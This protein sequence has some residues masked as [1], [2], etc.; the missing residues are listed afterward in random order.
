MCEITMSPEEEESQPK[1][2]LGV[3][4]IQFVLLFLTLIMNYGQRTS[5]SVAIIAMTE[6]TPPGPDIHT[7]PQWKDTD[8]ILSSF[9]W[10]YIVTQ[11]G[12]GQLGERFGPKW[13]LV[14][15]MVLGSIV[16]CLTT[17]MA[18]A[19]GSAGVITCQIIQGLNQGFLCPCVHILISQWAPLN[20]RTRFSII[21]YSGQSLGIVIS[22]LSTGAISGSKLGWPYVFYF[23]GAGGI[24]W[25]IIFGMFAANSPAD[26]KSISAEERRY[27]ESTNSVIQTKTK[28]PTPWLSIA[29]SLPFW[30]A[31]AAS[32]AENWGSYTL[33]T[34][35]P[36]FM[37]SVM[38]YDINSNSQLSALPYM[39]TFFVNFVSS[40]ISDKLISSKT[41]SIGTTRKIFNSLG[42]LVP[43]CAL[44]ALGFIDSTQKGVAVGLLVVSVAMSAC[45]DAGGFVN[46]IDLAPNHVGTLLGIT[47]GTGQIFSILAPLTVGFLGSD[48]TDLMLWR[49]VFWIA[50]GIYVFCGL[51]FNIFASGEVQKWNDVKSTDKCESESEEKS[52]ENLKFLGE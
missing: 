52:N 43:G 39:V 27:I 50:A 23:Y 44:F 18:Q 42:T 5:I 20:E 26:H 51:F 33:I 22:M 34:E 32:C 35:I 46:T 16:M 30:A 11:V 7:Y 31:L 3:R 12:A 6:K 24:V 19:W 38:N 9:F 40:P 13:F 17:V 36:S 25:A 15:T 29:T 10:G 28:I 37:D 1:C 45:A 47:N 14:G 8:T 49:K 48:K 2:K 41:L 21:V 4:H